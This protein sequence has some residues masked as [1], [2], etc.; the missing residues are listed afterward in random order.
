LQALAF[1]LLASSP[2]LAVGHA[3]RLRM[4]RLLAQAAG[5]TGMVAGQA[6][7]IAATGQPRDQAAPNHMHSLKTGALIRASVLLGALSTNVASEACLRALDRFAQL[8]GLAFQIQDDI[9]D[10]TSLTAVSGKQQGKDASLN[11]PTYVSLLG[12]DG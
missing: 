2:G 6:L 7:D 5:A 1:E 11:K 4:V 12:L 10:V 9:L 8:A 3:T